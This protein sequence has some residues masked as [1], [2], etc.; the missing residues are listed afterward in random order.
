MEL[1]LQE[2]YAGYGHA[3]DILRGVNLN[4]NDGELVCLIGPNGAGKSTILRVVSGILPCRNGSVKWGSD[5]IANL[6]P[7]H[8]LTKGISHVPQGRSVFPDMTVWENLLMGGY[9]LEDQNVLDERLQE[10]CEFF[11]LLE[12]RKDERASQLSGGQ[13]KMVELGR[14]LM[15]KPKMLLLDEPSLG[16]EPRLSNAV[17]Q[18][19]KE[20]NDAGITILMVEQNAR[21][22]LEICDTAYVLELGQIRLKGT[23][24]E[25]LND[26]RIKELY[27]GSKR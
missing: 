20:L 4:V 12:E 16:L 3:E 13:Q 10:V 5:Q 19:I 1:E 11:P 24:T 8:I 23:G 18:K 15:L 21:R 7:H 6:K 27:L 26:P 22:G 2:V 9:I 25:L 14:A 17:F